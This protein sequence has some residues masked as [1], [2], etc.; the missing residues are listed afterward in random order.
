MSLR[1]IENDSQ[2]RALN[3]LYEYEAKKKKAI[4]KKKH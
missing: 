1:Y 3:K 4:D 2:F